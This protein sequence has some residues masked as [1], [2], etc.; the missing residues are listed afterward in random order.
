MHANAS[1]KAYWEIQN[2]YISQA[3]VAT[4]GKSH[5]LNWHVQVTPNYIDSLKCHKYPEVPFLAD[6][7]KVEISSLQ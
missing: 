1:D 7:I 2:K 5:A 6:L 3:E 4:M